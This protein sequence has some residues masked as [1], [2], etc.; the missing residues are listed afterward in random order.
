LLLS[1]TSAGSICVNDTIMQFGG[2]IS[3]QAA[4]VEGGRNLA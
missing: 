4:A 2:E 1:Q 3:S